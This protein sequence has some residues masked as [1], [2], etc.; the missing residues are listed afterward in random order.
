[1]V[2]PDI[3]G[4]LTINFGCPFYLKYSPSFYQLIWRR[5]KILVTFKRYGMGIY[6]CDFLIAQIQKPSR[7]VS[8]ARMG[9]QEARRITGDFPAV[10]LARLL[11]KSL[12]SHL[13]YEDLDCIP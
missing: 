11:V 13:R 7:E 8:C 12:N 4:L 5:S 10:E 1:M 3:A 2:T 9:P 6:L